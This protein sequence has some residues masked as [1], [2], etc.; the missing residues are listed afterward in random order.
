MTSML[1]IYGIA[2]SRAKRCF[3]MAR[4][5]G[6]PFETVEVHFN[7]ARTSPI[8]LGINP[9][10]RVPAID[11]DG[12]QLFEASAINL[13]LAK[14]YGAGTDLMPASLED[15]ARATQWSFWV[16]TEIERQ[17]LGVLMHEQGRRLVDDATLAQLKSELDRPLTVLETT[18]ADRD[19]LL[20]GPF[21]VADLN[22]ASIIQWVRLAKM[23]L[24][25]YPR[26]AD[27]LER[28]IARPAFQG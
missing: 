9:N 27:W 12:F 4:E 11:D 28:C 10:G 15:E 3:W 22:V 20:G 19:Y 23:E 26:V 18:L 24:L 14:K 5:L 8:L 21:S 1:K 2:Q 13:Y 7:D 16:M 6:V 17:L 25:N